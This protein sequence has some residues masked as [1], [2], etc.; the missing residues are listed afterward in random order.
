MAGRRVGS[1]PVSLCLPLG[2]GPEL[3]GRRT[4]APRPKGGRGR[5]AHSPSL[6]EKRRA[7]GFFGGA[8]EQQGAAFLDGLQPERQE[9]D[10]VLQ[11]LVDLD[12]QA[13]EAVADGGVAGGQEG[14]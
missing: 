13:D 8:A 14:G 12:Q 4:L 11:A 2:E 9:G 3:Q 1:V 10:E 6:R 5:L 7:R